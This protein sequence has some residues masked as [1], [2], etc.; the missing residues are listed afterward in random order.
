[1]L[2]IAF[3]ADPELKAVDF[4]GIPFFALTHEEGA[5]AATRSDRRFGRLLGPACDERMDSY[6]ASGLAP[7]KRYPFTKGVLAFNVASYRWRTPAR[8]SA[9]RARSNTT[10]AR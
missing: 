10:R 4:H 6:E 5:V 7:E 2:D 1:M 9:G 8:P 3:D